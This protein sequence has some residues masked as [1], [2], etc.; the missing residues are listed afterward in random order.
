MAAAVGIHL[1]YNAWV[2]VTQA[3]IDTFADY[4]LI[5]LNEAFACRVLGVLRGWV[6]DDRDGVNA[7]GSGISLGHPLGA[8]GVHMLSTV[9]HELDRR[10]GRALL[11][12]CI[13]GGQGMVASVVSA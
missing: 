12:M 2:E 5:E 8:T 10:G 3:R 4:D 1:G 6:W 7:N 13:G 11:T 9:L